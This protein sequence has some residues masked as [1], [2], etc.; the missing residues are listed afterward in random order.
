M[1][2]ELPCLCTSRCGLEQQ[3]QW[4]VLISCIFPLTTEGLVLVLQHRHEN[5][6]SGLAKWAIPMAKVHGTIA[7]MLMTEAQGHS[8]ESAQGA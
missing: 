7:I 8:A 6:K 4:L 1:L 2:Q 3:Q 5:M